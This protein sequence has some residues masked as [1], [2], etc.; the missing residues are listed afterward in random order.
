MKAFKD[1]TGRMWEVAVDVGA[2]KRLRDLAG[3]DL[4]DILAKENKLI[5]RLRLEPI[6]LVDALYAICKPQADA[7][8]PPISDEDFGRS[9]DGE[10]LDG[11]ILAL[12]EELVSFFP[13]PTR[14]VLGAVVKRMKSLETLT[15]QAAQ[16][17]AR[18]KTI[19][20]PLRRAIRGAFGAKSGVSRGS[21]A[22]SRGG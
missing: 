19:E 14:Q 6:L 15:T 1:K 11:A 2:A 18:D 13:S 12:F 8:A 17:V 22:S 21:R 3:V 5:E 10:A 16:A 7:A 20:A 4:G 9:M